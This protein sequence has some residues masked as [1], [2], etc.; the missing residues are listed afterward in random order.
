MGKRK[1]IPVEYLVDL[2]NS[3]CKNSKSSQAGVRQGAM[4][5]LES[6]LHD[7][8]NYKGFR[9]LLASE[10]EGPPGVNYEGNMPHPDIGLRFEGTDRTR[11]QFYK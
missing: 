5:V 3:I 7:T 6:T 10:C 2:V 9:F 8:G 1:T 4:N 11:V